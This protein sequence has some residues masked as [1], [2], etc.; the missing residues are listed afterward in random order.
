MKTRPILAA[1]A[2]ARRLA[3]ATTIGGAVSAPFARTL[4]AV[5]V[6]SQ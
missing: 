5:L 2:S 3:G 1:N 4:L 6:Q